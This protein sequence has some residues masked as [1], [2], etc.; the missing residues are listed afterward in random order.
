VISFG[1]SI[2]HNFDKISSY[3]SE[4]LYP[5]ELSITITNGRISTNVRE[6]Y[7]ITISPDKI[8]DLFSTKDNPEDRVT[9]MRL[10]SIDT[11]AKIEDFDRYQ[12]Y[13]LLTGSSLVYKRNGNITV[14]PLD[15]IDK[16]EI[17]KEYINSR[18][19]LIKQYIQNHRMQLLILCLIGVLLL[20]QFT[21]LFEGLLISI[22]L[23]TFSIVIVIVLKLEKLYSSY[24]SALR[25]CLKIFVP[26]YGLSLIPDLVFKIH[27]NS[28]F[29]I[30]SVAV[31]YLFIY[32][33]K[34]NFTKSKKMLLAAGIL[35]PL[36]IVR[37]IL[38]SDHS[39]FKKS[40]YFALIVGIFSV[41]WLRVVVTV[42]NITSYVLYEKGLIDKTSKIKVSGTSML[43]T[44][45]NGEEVVLHSIQ[46]YPIERNDIVSFKN[47]ETENSHFL[48][49]VVGMPGDT[50][51][52]KQGSIILNGNVLNEPYVRYGPT[53]GNEYLTECKSYTIPKDSYAVM[54]DN[55]IVSFDTRAIGFIN[56]KDINGIIKDE[57]KH[58]SA[59]NPN[60]S[61]QITVQI[62]KDSLFEKYNFNRNNLYL[63][64]LMR[65]NT[66]DT[67]AEKRAVYIASNLDS[68]KKDI[69]LLETTLQ[70]E[71]YKE[72]DSREFVTFGNLSEEQILNQISEQNNVKLDFYSNTFMDIGIS[73]TQT[74]VDEC[75]IPV[76]V[77][78]LARSENPMYP[79]Q[80]IDY[81][82]DELNNNSDIVARLNSFVGFPGMDEKEFA[83]LKSQAQEALQIVSE[84][85]REIAAGEWIDQDLINKYK[86]IV[87]EASPNLDKF[88]ETTVD[89]KPVSL[90]TN[91]EEYGPE[92]NC[93]NQGLKAIE[94]HITVKVVKVWER[95]NRVY[96]RVTFANDNIAES[97]QTSPY[98]LLM[99]SEGEYTHPNQAPSTVTLKP[100]E[101]IIYDFNY[102][103]LSAKP[104]VFKYVKTGNEIELAE[105]R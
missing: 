31:A 95:D 6:P 87:N 104:Y 12:T 45:K 62:N 98:L 52:I 103:K 105:C 2:Y 22:F 92:I 101:A 61:T 21:A 55:R 99:G 100:G 79:K 90:K 42:S 54:G 58:Q 85:N 23:F 78:L 49:R 70:K 59:I 74:K 8:F 40:L 19:T 89:T 77:V 14:T 88:M 66:L 63:N 81:W 71:G 32:R 72:V 28:L 24:S 83:T 37:D 25:F 44:I 46:K 93:F 91:D 68:W 60:E 97:E 67:V 15:N 7:H 75:T 102:L 9:K 48:K 43:P 20:W 94:E 18:I 16:L 96:A 17:N 3:I 82:K 39:I 38:V 13:A 36:F 50:I 4:E 73:Q 51:L 57:N 86:S 27:L 30:L 76:T 41:C 10:L 56:K 65:N 35:H 26:I 1:W 64:P 53:Y 69:E 29:F 47:K 11:K 34:N 80:T 84:I 33:K 5:A